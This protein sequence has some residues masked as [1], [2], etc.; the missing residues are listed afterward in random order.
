MK[1]GFASRPWLIVPICSALHYTY[2]IGTFFDHKVAYI[3]GLHFAHLLFHPFLPYVLFTVASLA[4]LPMVRELRPQQVHLFLWPQQFMLMLMFMSTLWA[5]YSGRYP[6]GYQANSLF[7]FVDQS[8]SI[9]LTLGHLA[10]MIRNSKL[11]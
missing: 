8:F 3:T 9:W 6:D 5:A 1:T 4:I 10:A 7:I 2:S 11:Q